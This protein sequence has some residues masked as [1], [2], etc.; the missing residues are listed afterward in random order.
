MWTK[1][2]NRHFSKENI[3]MVNKHMNKCSTSLII[4]EMQIKTTV[5]NTLPEPE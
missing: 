4:K 3:Q 5:Y 1:D 2:M